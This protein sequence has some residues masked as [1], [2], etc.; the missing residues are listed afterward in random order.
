MSSFIKSTPQYD[1]LLFRE[2]YDVP[3][4][5]V[6][7]YNAS[8]F[9]AVMDNKSLQTLFLLL[10][11]R[12]GNNPIANRDLGQWHIKLFSVVFQYGPT[13]EKRL[14]IQEKLRKLS[15][16][17]LVR[18]SKAIYNRAYN[19][20]SNPGTASLEELPYINDQSTSAVIRPKL[21]SYGIL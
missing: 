15:D 6:D 11:G 14:E 21:E 20:D 4:N 10:M 8:G 19:P 16:D 7:D 2:I 1:T 9:P 17:E 12:Y 13:W 5:F 18:S 3:A